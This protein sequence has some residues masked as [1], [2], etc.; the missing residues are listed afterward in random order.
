MKDKVKVVLEGLHPD[1]FIVKNEDI[2]ITNDF[3]HGAFRYIRAKFYMK[4][5]SKPG[6]WMHEGKQ[7]AIDGEPWG[8]SG[9]E[10]IQF[11]NDDV[12]ASMRSASL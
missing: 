11:S 3:V 12:D 7:V 6:F 10:L 4:G 5:K 2:T 1:H 9:A 8:I